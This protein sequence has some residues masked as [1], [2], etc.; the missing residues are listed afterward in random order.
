[1]RRLRLFQGEFKLNTTFL[2][3]ARVDEHLA[4]VVM[5]GGIVGFSSIASRKA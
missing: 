2:R 4:E 1:L 3:P 5:R